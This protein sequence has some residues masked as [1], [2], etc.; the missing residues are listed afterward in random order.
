VRPLGAER[1]NDPNPWPGARSS[2]AD[3][4]RDALVDY[5]GEHLATI[6]RAGPKKESVL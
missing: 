6:R 5:E 2:L 4:L 1:L 3:Y